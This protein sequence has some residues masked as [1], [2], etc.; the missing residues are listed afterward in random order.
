[1]IRY[2]LKCANAHRF[3]SWFKSAESY[4]TLSGAGHVACPECGSTQVEKA[5][6]APQVSH[7]RSTAPDETASYLSTPQDPRAK[8]LAELR[9][10]VEETSD[11]VGKDFATEA[12]RIH[13]GE[14]PSRSIY[15]E[16]RVDEAAKLLEDGIAVAPL[17]FTPKARAN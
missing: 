16:A 14:A 11:Y 6:M 7:G 12:R 10:K 3:E 1:M 8:A 13:D 17:P 4:D 2:A 9:R 15:G 5:L